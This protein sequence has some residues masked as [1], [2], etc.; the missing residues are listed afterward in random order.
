MKKIGLFILAFLLVSCGHKELT[1]PLGTGGV[2]LQ[3]AE[4]RSLQNFNRDNIS[5]GLVAFEKSCEIILKKNFKPAQSHIVFPLEKYRE[6][7]VKYQA[8]KPAADE[9]GRVFLEQ[10]FVPYL[11]L[12]EGSP[13]GK[14]TSYYEAEINASHTRHG[15]Y[16]YPV[17]G[18]PTDL[19][20]FNPKDF[21]ESLPSKRLLGRIEKN[22]LVPYYTRAEIE[23]GL[24]AAPVILWADDPVDVFLMQIQG[25]AIAKFDNGK[26]ARVRYADNNGRPF[27]GIGSILLKEKVLPKGGASMDKIRDWLKEN[28]EL[29][30]KYMRENPR[31]VFHQFSDAEGPVGA[32]GATL[33]AGRSLAVDKTYIPLGSLLWLETTSPHKEPIQKLVA[34]QDI[35]GAIKGAVRGDYFWGH[36]G[37]A[38]LS[39]GKMHAEGQYYILLPKGWEPSYQ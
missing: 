25:S 4:F 10:N 15:L 13:K 7:C 23:S 36:G 22:K 29:A 17:Y 27:V 3:K 35:G 33:T 1:A 39:A 31:F 12:F 19:I 28:P 14:F 24:I 6:I 34:A 16:Q 5:E 11:V 9:E 20:A 18:K 26:E 38:L 37:D 2:V 32:L 8:Q 21:D 30:K